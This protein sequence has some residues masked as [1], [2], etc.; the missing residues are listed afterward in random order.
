MRSPVSWIAALLALVA[1]AV[2]AVV[3]TVAHRAHVELLGVDLPTGIV[4]GVLAVACLL[5]GIRLLSA[6]RLPVIGAGVGVVGTIMLLAAR[7][8]HGSVLIADGALGIAWLVVPSAIAAV[9]IVWP[10][11]RRP[12]TAE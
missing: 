12:Q 7:G 4:L 8:E 5:I 6:D 10:A 11:R 3:F 9:V 1:G 2:L